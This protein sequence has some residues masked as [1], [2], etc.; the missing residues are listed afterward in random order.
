MSVFSSCTENTG[1]IGIPPYNETLNTSVAMWDVYSSSY[2]I[3]SIRANS[4]SSYLGAIYDPETNGKL[5]ANFATQFAVLEDVNY[6]P[7]KDSIVSVGTDG[8]PCCDSVFLQLNF[9][10]YYGDVNTPIKLAVY[11]LDIDNPLSEDS[12]Y[13][14]T[15]DLRNIN[16]KYI[17]R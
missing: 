1:S 17:N 12:I 3:D 7:H 16:K 9:D 10:T 11:P 14:T 6:F 8:S 13:Y 2:K 15:T 4:I 5:V